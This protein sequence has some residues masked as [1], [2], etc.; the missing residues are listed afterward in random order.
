M[1]TFYAI[2]SAKISHREYWWGTRSPAVLIGWLVKWLR[3]RLPSSTD[4]PKLP[5][6]IARPRFTASTG[7]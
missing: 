6:F 3:I 1:S 5:M 2:D 7:P 4:D